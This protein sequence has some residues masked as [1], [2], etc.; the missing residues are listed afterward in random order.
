ML[1]PDQGLDDETGGQEKL[2]ILAGVN[3]RQRELVMRTL[4][5]FEGITG[6]VPRGRVS[7][8]LLRSFPGKRLK[9]DGGRL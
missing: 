5:R 4:A 7:A 6:L 2:R 1:T 9:G 8:P 3:W